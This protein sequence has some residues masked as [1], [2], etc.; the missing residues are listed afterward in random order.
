MDGIR[1]YL[2]QILSSALICSILTRLM[3]NKGLLT[4]AVKLLAGIYM[5]ISVLGPWL[6]LPKWDFTGLSGE[7]TANAD[8]ITDSGKN[9]AYQAMADI[10]KAQTEAYI[11]DKAN[12]LGASLTVEVSLTGGS[13]PYPHMVTLSGSISPYG[14]SVLITYISEN[15]GISREDQTWIG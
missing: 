5:A 3:G 14:K 1:D 6:H 12:A 8:A 4:E 13:V 10:I 7:I 15:L 2:L 9:S 11:L